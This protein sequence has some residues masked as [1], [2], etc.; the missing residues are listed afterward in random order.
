MIQTFSPGHYVIEGIRRGDFSYFFKREIALRKELRYPPLYRLVRIGLRGGNEERVKRRGEE[1][2]TQL[3]EA[4]IEALGP[5]PIG[6]RKG[7]GRW[8][9]LVKGR[10][11][12]DLL[13][14]LGEILR[15][16]RKGGVKI[17]VDV[18][19]LSVL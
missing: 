9:I 11:Y 8:Q 14:A 5:S 6:F 2:I 19:P 3:R 16:R 4:G 1:I 13:P 7:E 15:E 17:E 18:D 12:A 10:R